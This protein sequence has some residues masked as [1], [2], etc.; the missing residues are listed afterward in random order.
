LFEKLDFLITK[1][2]G[3]IYFTYI[4]GHDGVIENEIADKLAKKELSSYNTFMKFNLPIVK[5]N[6]PDLDHKSA[7][8]LV[9]SMWKDSINNPK[10][11]YSKYL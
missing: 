1:R 6:N 11:N 8:K 7:F 5:K 9:A 10:N 3:K 4:F 2:N